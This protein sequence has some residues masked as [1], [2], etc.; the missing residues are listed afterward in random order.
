M[1]FRINCLIC[2][3]TGDRSFPIDIDKN[4]GNEEVAFLKGLIKK[5]MKPRL[6]H[7]AASDLQ[8]FEV[9]LPFTFDFKYFKPDTAPLLPDKPL[10][11]FQR[12]ARN[13]VHVIV[14]AGIFHDLSFLNIL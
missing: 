7:F 6:D 9:D 13:H 2:G 5:A 1:A 4:D 14:D 12:R 10:K 8:L 11:M 3:H